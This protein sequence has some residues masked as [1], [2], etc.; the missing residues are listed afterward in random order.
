MRAAVN[1]R[2]ES[3]DRGA[4]TLRC[5]GLTDR[6]RQ[7]GPRDGLFRGLDDAGHHSSCCERG[8]K[9]FASIHLTSGVAAGHESYGVITMNQAATM[10]P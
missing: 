2:G 4:S 6:G 1:L 9:R 5:N 3:L 10:G 7:L 8:D